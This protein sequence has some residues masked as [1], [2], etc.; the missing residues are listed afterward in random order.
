MLIRRISSSGQS[1]IWE[2]NQYIGTLVS[3]ISHSE[4]LLDL[5]FS[6]FYQTDLTELKP[7]FWIAQQNKGICWLSMD[8]CFIYI[9]NSFEGSVQV[10]TRKFTAS[11]TK[12]G[13]VMRDTHF[14][15]RD[16]APFICMCMIYNHLLLERSVSLHMSLVRTHGGSIRGH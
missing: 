9:Y 7:R 14:K 15:Q 6:S 4:Q 3:V 5:L 13:A 2:V 16:Y 11:V 12:S 10:K 8:F 1:V